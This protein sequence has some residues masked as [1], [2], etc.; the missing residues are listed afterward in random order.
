M[1]PKKIHYC[2]FG[3]NEIPEKD[4]KCIESWKKYCPD[5]EIILWDESNYDITKNRYMQEAYQAKKW[6]FVPDFARLDILYE[7]G[8]IYLDTDVELIKNIDHL[9]DQKAFMGFESDG[10][11]VNPG[12]II[13]AE[14]HMPLIGEIRDSIYQNRVFKLRENEYD[15]TAS[16]RMN[17]DFLV[18]KG[19]KRNNQ[20]QVVEGLTVY[21][22]DY[23]CPIDFST[24]ILKETPNTLSIHHFHASWLEPEERCIML[25]SQSLTAKYGKNKAK[26]LMKF[27]SAYYKL[28][29]HLRLTG[30]AGTIGFLMRKF[31]HKH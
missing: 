14:A 5:Y 3:G 11:S 24:N 27:I 8:G 31:L 23:F 20:L 13:G 28:K 25:C 17:T 9:L 10:E 1:I 6:G 21:P 12:L 4:K 29:M 7:H 15:T 19:M 26:F 18:S 16:P 30:L 2:W 22:S